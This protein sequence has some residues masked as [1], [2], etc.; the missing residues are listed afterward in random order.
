MYNCACII[1]NLANLFEQIIPRT[2]GELAE[3][4]NIDISD[5]TEVEVKNSIMLNGEMQ[6]LFERIK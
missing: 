3:Y 6:P 2:F 1:A 4:L 5:W